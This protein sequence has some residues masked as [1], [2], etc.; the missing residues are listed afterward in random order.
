MLRDLHRRERQHDRFV[1]RRLLEPCC[2]FLSDTVDGLSMEDLEDM[3]V[4]LF[5]QGF[6]VKVYDF[7]FL[8]SNQSL[9]NCKK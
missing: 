1:F 6:Y 5:I 2:F 7:H 3:L 9:F 8:L 4:L